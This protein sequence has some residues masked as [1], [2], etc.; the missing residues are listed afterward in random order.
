MGVKSMDKRIKVLIIGSD[1]SVK[2]GIT[3]VIDRFLNYNWDGIEVELLPTY[4]EGNSIK[5]ILFFF[6]SIIKYLYKLIKNDFNIAHIHMSYK[7]SFFRKFV[8][9]KIGNL[10]KKK[11]ILHLHGSE[12]KVFYE[13]S[14]KL[15]KKLIKN[16]LENCDSV[17]VL[18]ENWKEATKQISPQC[19]I[20]IFNNAVNV[21]NYT[22]EWSESE[23]TILFLGVIIK[24]KGVYDLIESIRLLDKAGVIKERNIK[25]IIGGSGAEEEN[26]KNKINEY[27]LGYC[28][29]M[30]GWVNGELKEKLLKKAQLFILPSYNEGLPMAILEAMSYGIPVIST[31]VGSIA[32]AVVD[33]ETGLLIRPGEIEK[34]VECITN[35][36][37]DKVEW[38]NKSNACKRIIYNKF[39]EEKYFNNINYMYRELYTIKE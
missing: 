31:D 12:F 6:K 21:P 13:N 32:E 28:T 1:S 25:F 11:L 2:G 36:L 17:I 10:F 20:S 8:I 18:G 34:M 33:N 3:S 39:N 27:N 29:K 5:K 38:Q 37:S 7:G 16:I 9:V 15:V 23:I 35:I 24:R 30:K 22:V 14:S 26:V 4:I 19:N